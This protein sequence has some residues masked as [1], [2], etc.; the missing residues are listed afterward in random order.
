MNSG[1]NAHTERILGI[2]DQVGLR[3]HEGSASNA[4]INLAIADF[5]AA[6]EDAADDAFLSPGLAFAKF[7]V[8]VET[9]EFGAG[10]GAARRPVVGFAGTQNEILAIDS[11]N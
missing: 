10:S 3:I 4:R 9:G 7:A 6:F 5:D 11:G 1:T 2:E 8:R